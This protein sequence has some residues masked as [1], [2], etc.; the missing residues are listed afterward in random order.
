[1]LDAISTALLIALLGALIACVVWLLWQHTRVVAD[2]ENL[3]E[4]IEYENHKETVSEYARR[5]TNADEHG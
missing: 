5:I 1:M 4:A 2:L 3:Y